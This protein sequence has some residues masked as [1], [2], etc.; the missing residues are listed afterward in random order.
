MML[1]LE[2]ISLEFIGAAIDEDVAVFR[3]QKQP[4]ND[5][6]VMSITESQYEGGGG[7]SIRFGHN[8]RSSIKEDLKCRHTECF[9]NVRWADGRYSNKKSSRD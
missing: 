5:L 9:W 4:N 1:G 6:P 3:L 8:L 2:I 7:P